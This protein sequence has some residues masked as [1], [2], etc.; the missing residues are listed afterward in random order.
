[1]NRSGDTIYLKL[2]AEHLAAR[3]ATT[4]AGIRP[5]L[6]HKSGDELLQFIKDNLK[7]REPYYLQAKYIIEGNDQ[8]I[9]RRLI[10]LEF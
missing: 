3:L 5:I 4:K 6:Q 9:E 7:H 2:S 1:M 10:Q 8:E